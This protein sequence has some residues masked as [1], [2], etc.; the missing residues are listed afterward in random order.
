MKKKI[1]SMILTVSVIGLICTAAERVYCSDDAAKNEPNTFFQKMGDLING[2]YEMK[3][4]PMKK[5]EVFQD[6]SNGIKEGSAKARETSLR[7]QK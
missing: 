2:K 5:I 1:L 7:D 4:E 6:V 3:V